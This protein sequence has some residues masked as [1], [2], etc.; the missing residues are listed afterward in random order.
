M[1]TQVE[2]KFTWGFILSEQEL[3][4]LAQTCQE[5]IT[6]EFKPEEYRTKIT[7]TLKDGSILETNKLDDILSLENSG[8]KKVQGL[9]LIYDDG[10]EESDWGILIHFQDANLSTRSWTSMCFSAVGQSRD[11]AFLAA[12][13]IEERLRKIK[14]QSAIFYLF[15]N[16]LSIVI[17]VAIGSVLF[18]VIALN[19]SLSTKPAI[20]Q[21]EAA[22][23]SGVVTNPIEAMIYFERAKDAARNQGISVYLITAFLS[24][25]SP[26]LIWWLIGKYIPVIAPSY[27]FYWGDYVAYYDKR[28]STQ[29]VFWT[30]VV[31]G[32]LVSI[33]SAYII[34]FLP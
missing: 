26:S 32:I 29:G 13:D 20:D 11:W 19:S 9:T 23:K 12:S 4:R 10:K 28:K 31:L 33:I 16:R 15:G 25:V 22:Y 14:T 2:K 3:R 6:K 8:V 21:L 17:P 30:V 7:A 18:L 1:K 5:H 34:R 24:Y 27:N